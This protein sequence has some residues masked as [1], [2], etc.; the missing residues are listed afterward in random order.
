MAKR[1]KMIFKDL[2]TSLEKLKKE[3]EEEVGVELKSK[4]KELT[5]NGEEK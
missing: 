2:S 3:G 5:D 1:L 4:I